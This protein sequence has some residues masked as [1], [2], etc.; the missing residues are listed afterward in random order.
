MRIIFNLK[1]ELPSSKNEF[2]KRSYNY[3]KINNSIVLNRSIGS[4]DWTY[5]PYVQLDL[6]RTIHQGITRTIIKLFT[7]KLKRYKN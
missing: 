7:L 4:L 5:L 1:I 3:K 6:R 2:K